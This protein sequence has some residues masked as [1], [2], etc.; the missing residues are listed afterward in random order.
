MMFSGPTYAYLQVNRTCSGCSLE[1]YAPPDG[2][3]LTLSEAKDIA[4][5][6]WS[7]KVFIVLIDGGEPLLWDGIA[8][9]VRHFR[10]KPMAT[11][12]VSGGEDISQANALKEADLSMIQF[13]LD[14]P[15]AYHDSVRGEGMFQKT[16]TAIKTFCNLGIDTHVGTVLSS[17]NIHFLEQISDIVSSFPVLIHRVLR[18]IHASE[19]LTADQCE[20]VLARLAL[21][22][23]K[24]R[25]IAPTNCYTF[26]HQTPYSRVMN[27]NKFQGCVGGKT[28]AVITCEGYVVPCPHFASKSIAESIQAPSIWE[29]DIRTIWKEWDFLK[30]FRKGLKACQVCPVNSL[31]GGCRAAAYHATGSFDYDPGCPLSSIMLETITNK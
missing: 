30:E 18:Y 28:S 10:S 31:C 20:D 29:T 25:A 2:A 16:L 11:S 14:G 5:M 7:A 22:R 26:A 1:C 4:D 24:K 19:Y 6:L 23:D 9:L 27:V 12:I 17:G 13:P 21:L 15:E 8:E 3:S